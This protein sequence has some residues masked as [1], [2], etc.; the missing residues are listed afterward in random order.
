MA[1]KRA[2]VN[3]L[4]PLVYLRRNAAKN[5]PLT[6]V[7]VMAVML[8]AGIISMINSIPLSIRTI[9]SYS[10]NFAG[11]T[12][13][14]DST[15]T[16]IIL[17]E[18]KAK[19]PVPVGRVITCRTI[20]T[21]VQSIVG[22]W[23][24]Y[25]LGLS[26]DD[27]DYYLNMQG[28]TQ[29]KG[30]L[31]KPGAAEAVVSEPVARNLNLKL[32]SELLGPKKDEG[33]SPNSVKI[34]GIAITRQWVMVMPIDYM[35]A[36]HFPPIDLGIVVAKNPADQDR[37]DRWAEKHFKGQRAAILAY[38]Q[39]EKNTSEMFKTLYQILNVVIGTLVLVITFMMGMLINI[40]QS[41][42]LVEF[43]LLQAIGFTKKKI[44]TRVL[45]ETAMVVVVGWLLGLLAAY[46]L[47]NVADAVLMAPRAYSLDALDQ[48]AYLYSIPLPLAILVV[49]AA[50]IIIRFRNFDPIGVVE[51][52]IV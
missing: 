32:G 9:Y 31:P 24:F 35:K 12:P 3:P 27:M 37:L 21:V 19:S 20:G 36:N 40:Y 5:I 39:I 49:A 52:R 14:G 7:I 11:V 22:K 30:R 38:H 46:G 8:V 34:V 28:M 1:S 50:T 42:R 4:A 51:R 43:G 25:I 18:I 41:Q 13:R 26:P 29:L 48:T 44:L 16:P 6:A 15:R 10:R 23:P 33:Y 47:L 45:T 17:A 2:V